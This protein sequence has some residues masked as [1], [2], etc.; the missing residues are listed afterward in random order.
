MGTFSLRPNVSLNLYMSKVDEPG[1]NRSLV[2]WDLQ[3]NE[4]VSQPTWNLNL[5]SSGTVSFSWWNGSTA[6]AIA[7]FAFDFRP[8]GLQNLS[9]GSGSFYVGHQSNGVGGT[10]SGSA[11]CAATSSS[12][13]LGTAT[14]S[15]AIG[16]SDY[17]RSPSWAS[18]STPSPV[19]RGVGYSGNFTANAASS[20]GVIA[21]TFPPGLS[22][23][24]GN[25]NITGTPNTDGSFNFTVRAYG[26]FEGAVDA[27]RTIVVNPPQP[28]FSDASIAPIAIRGVA[29]SDGVA[30]SETS[31]YAIV[32]GSLPSGLSLNASTGAITGTPTTLQSR[33]LV[34][35]A[36]NYA[37]SRDTGSLSLTVNPPAP[38]FTDSTLITEASIGS[39]Y[40]DQVVATDAASYS[41]FSG[42]LPLGLSLN[43]STGVV[44]GTPTTAGEYT[45]VLRATNV[46]GSTNMASR[47]IT[48]IS[49]V[50]VWDGDEFVIGSLDVWDGDEF[51]TGVVKV[52]NGTSWVSAV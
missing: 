43:T 4:T 13:G 44:S 35:R 23:N 37:S 6:P 38:V 51:V 15:N 50:R 1:N 48:V 31:N 11:T 3:L 10:V 8:T 45:F 17:D 2:Y 24:T 5:A 21:G 52:W 25:G 7:N 28:V 36:S 26:A 14:A 49:P 12:N 32:S 47:T 27:N 46:T 19:T 16:L 22:F 20:Y 30:A 41:V 18:I 29:Y 33:T 42:A 9:I 34:I 40:S 39:S